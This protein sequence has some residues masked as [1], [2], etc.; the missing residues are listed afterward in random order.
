MY[1]PHQLTWKDKW[2]EACHQLLR[3]Y[4]SWLGFSKGGDRDDGCAFCRLAKEL[5]DYYTDKGY[6]L[7]G[8]KCQFCV[9]IHI[10]DNTCGDWADNNGYEKAVDGMR[11]WPGESQLWVMKRVWMLKQWITKLEGKDD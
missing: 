10:E 3:Y 9:W 1:P 7:V 6:A 11:R 2:L 5:W 8:Q 4:E